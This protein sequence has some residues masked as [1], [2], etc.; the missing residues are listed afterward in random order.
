MSA[1]YGFI[2]LRGGNWSFEPS[3]VNQ[4]GFDFCNGICSFEGLDAQ[5]VKALMDAAYSDAACGD[6]TADDL[7]LMDQALCPFKCD[8]DSGLCYA[9]GWSS[10]AWGTCTV[11]AI[12]DDLP[13]IEVASVLGEYVLTENPEV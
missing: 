3:T 1:Y 12:R 9:I 5:S 11:M 6:A 7:H 8:I 10:S 4:M 13:G 2:R